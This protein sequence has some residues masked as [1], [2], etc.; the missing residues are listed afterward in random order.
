MA[1]P[2]LVRRVASELG[3][4]V[5][6]PEPIRVSRDKFVRSESERERTIV[7]ARAKIE[8]SGAILVILDSDGDCPATLGPQL[9]QHV[10]AC[11]GII[12]TGLVFAHQEFEA[13]FLAAAESLQG[14]RELSPDL[15]A[16]PDPEA[17][18]DA[19]GWLRQR[20]PAERAYS[21]TAD[22]PAFTTLFDMQMARVRST[23][24]DKCYR[25]IS[26]L[27]RAVCGVE[28][29]PSVSEGSSGASEV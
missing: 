11:A 18:R 16:A 13:W 14:K 22:Q 25:E 17:V 5:Q 7:L 12:A 3:G 20:M 24:F 27:V 4:Y 26:R 15:A 1:V 29:E 21:E 2:I 10:S 8:D 28:E 19:K 6:C 23:S 9:L